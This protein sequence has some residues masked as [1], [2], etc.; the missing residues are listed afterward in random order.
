ME[1]LPQFQT[2]PTELSGWRGEEIPSDKVTAEVLAADVTSKRVYTGAGGTQVGVFVAYFAQ[3]QVNSQIHSP[4][5]CLPGAGWKPISITER[6]FELSGAPTDATR[7]VVRRGEHQS[8]VLYWFRTRSG[9][10]TGEYALKWDLVKNSIA[11]RP[12]DAAFIR[13]TADY[14]DSSALRDFM[15]LFEPHLDRV[16]GDV[17]L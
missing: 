4:R 15:T 5:N 13:Y 9:N 1:H 2:L 6:K 12:T 14:A 16:L 3:Q 11:R 8:V 10:V 7:M 17:G